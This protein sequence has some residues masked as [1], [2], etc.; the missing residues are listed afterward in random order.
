[1]EYNDVGIVILAA[2]KGT[3][4]KSDKP[5]VIH[6]VA[7]KGMV[8]HVVE[9]ARKITH[10][11][12]YVVVGHKA[13]DVKREINKYFKVN[14][15]EQKQLIGTGDAVKSSL[16]GIDPAIKDIL[17]LCGDVPLIKEDTIKNLII[18]HKQNRSLVSV[19]VIDVDDP[20]GYGR[21]ILD[22]YN[23]LLCIKE[24]ADATFDEKKIKK[25]NTGIYCF[26]KKFLK[27]ALDAISP[28]NNQAEYYLTDVIEIA[29]KKNKKILVVS[30]DDY[31][32]V[33]GVNTV[34]QFNLIK[35]L[36]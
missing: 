9:T 2:G 16:T 1:M 19:L 17:V 8:V 28:D 20:N 5:K 3:R 6:K 32:Q 34:E 10:D 26:D 36:I 35:K 29:Q 4:M 11:N 27:S 33:I 13:G 12:I 24:E 7:G 22:D 25:I 14:F 18:Q 30:M 15:A 21:I 31:N 23:N